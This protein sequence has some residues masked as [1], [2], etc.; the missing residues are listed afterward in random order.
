MNISSSDVNARILLIIEF[1]FFALACLILYFANPGGNIIFYVVVA[2]IGI[3]MYSVRIYRESKKERNRQLILNIVNSIAANMEVEKILEDLMPVL[4]E[5]TGSNCGA[6]YLAN[7]ATSKLEIKHS[8][9][10]SKNIY[11]E[12]DLSLGEGI[13]GQ[14]AINQEIRIMRDIPDDTTYLMRTFLGTAKPKSIMVVPIV[15]QDKLIGVFAFASIYE[16]SAWQQ[17]MLN[18]I[19]YYVGAAV[20]NGM[21]YEKT[22]R[23]SNELK[24]Q[25]RLIQNLNDDLER[26]VQERTLFHNEILNSIADHAI[27]AIDKGGSILVWNKG[28]ELLF[29]YEAKEMLGKSVDELYLPQ[30]VRDG[31]VQALLIKA[32]QHGKFEEEG[33]RHRPDG[34]RYYAETMLFARYSQQGEFLGYTNVTKDT[35][36]FKKEEEQ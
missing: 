20:N 8:V 10:F 23:L 6:F 31:V 14:A 5:V 1:S 16:Y 33:W 35:T 13:I 27:Y 24:F 3:F 25:N 4:L 34:S 17:E 26:K 30:E 12:F 28:A 18:L 19:K 22:K 7:H 36:A 11:A 32:Q 9:G 29:G 15:N 2:C 21:T